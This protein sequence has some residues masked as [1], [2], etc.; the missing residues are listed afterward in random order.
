GA[1]GGG[2]AGARAAPAGGERGWGAHAG[3]GGARGVGGGGVGGL[4]G[5]PGGGA[6]GMIRALFGAG[7]EPTMVEARGSKRRLA[8]P[9][10][11]IAAGIG[12][13]PG[14]RALGLIMNQSVRDNILL[15]NLDALARLGWFDRDGGDRIVADA[16]ELIDIRPRPP[17]LKASALSGGNRQDVIPAKW[18]ARRVAALLPRWPT[19][20]LQVAAQL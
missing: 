19:P 6:D 11:A 18:L 4:A 13:V 1:G 17:E 10:D 7:S 16:M 14:E 3:G 12:M 20:R 9:A 15:P 5:R 2:G 8:S